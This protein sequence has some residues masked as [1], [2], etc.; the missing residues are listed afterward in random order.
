MSG[1]QFEPQAQHSGTGRMAPLS[2]VVHRV[3]WEDVRV[4]LGAEFRFAPDDPLLVTVVLRSEDGP[5]VTWHLGRDLLCEGL[6]ESS[7]IG[8]VRAWPVH[9]RGRSLLRLRLATRGA[10]ALF[11]IDRRALEKWLFDT[12]DMVPAGEELN[13]VDW[14][15]L[16]VG[17]LDGR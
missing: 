4:P 10:S 6:L 11:E 15:A 5:A 16:L 14:D 3:L 1:N 2:L 17:L 13:D 9:S 8:D 7:G 12:C